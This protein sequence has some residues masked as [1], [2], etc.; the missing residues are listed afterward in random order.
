[1]KVKKLKVYKVTSYKELYKLD[2]PRS[3]A[4]QALQTL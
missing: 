4:W 1:L 2:E 3:T